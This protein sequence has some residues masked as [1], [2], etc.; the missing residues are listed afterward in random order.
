MQ[1]FLG[2]NP[3]VYRLNAD[4]IHAE[5]L[6]HYLGHLEGLIGDGRRFEG[7]SRRLEVGADFGSAELAEDLLARWSSLR[8]PLRRELALRLLASRDRVPPAG[9]SDR[10]LER[11]LKD[12]LAALRDGDAGLDG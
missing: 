9:L 7:V 10:A 3:L 11:W 5:L 6:E 4:L 8:R 2:F 1:R 12:H